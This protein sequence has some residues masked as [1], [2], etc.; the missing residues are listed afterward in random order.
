MLRQPLA[1]MLLVCALLPLSAC[2]TQHQYDDALKDSRYHQTKLHDAESE[3]ARLQSENEK[4]KK[5]AAQSDVAAL[6]EAGFGDLDSRLSELQSK[7]DGLGH[8]LNDIERINVDGGYV[9]LVQ[10]KILFDSGSSDLNADGKGSI[11]KIVEEITKKPH[12]RISVRGHTDSDP[13]SKPQ[14][15]ARFPHG[16]IQLSAMRAIEVATALSKSGKVEE[17]DL[18]VAGFGPYDPLKPNTS[19][20]NKRMNR[21]VEIFVSDKVA[22]TPAAAKK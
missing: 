11:T 15:L 6:S 14:T 18:S 9:L 13:V 21:R 3:T 2:V 10:D 8:P 1:C 7:I 16:N 4:L 22:T 19:A 12:G 17:R 20:E 5:G